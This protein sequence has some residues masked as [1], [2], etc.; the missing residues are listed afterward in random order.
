MKWVKGETV[1][2]KGIVSCVVP[3]VINKIA[4]LWR[5]KLSSRV[6]NSKIC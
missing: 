1:G 2:A 3:M 5:F 6:L 4:T